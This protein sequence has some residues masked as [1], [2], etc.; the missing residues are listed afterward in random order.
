MRILQ[1]SQRDMR[2]ILHSGNE[3]VEIRLEGVAPS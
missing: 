2:L 3:K 1:G